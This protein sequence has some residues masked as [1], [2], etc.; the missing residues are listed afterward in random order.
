MPSASF[1]LTAIYAEAEMQSIA[2]RYTP[3]G[4]E[5]CLLTSMYFRSPIEA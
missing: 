3:G 2:R 4:V 5:Y 1:R